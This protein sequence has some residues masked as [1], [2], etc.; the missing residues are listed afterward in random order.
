VLINRSVLK[1]V[2]GLWAL[3][4]AFA[5]SSAAVA[6]TFSMIDTHLE[7]SMKSGCP[8]Q[9]TTHRD[10]SKMRSSVR[11]APGGWINR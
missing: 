8:D 5:S 2:L 10:G 4:F 11:S 7:A 3:I 9:P 6:C 1:S